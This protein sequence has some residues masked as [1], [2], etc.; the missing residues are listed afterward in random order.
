MEIRANQKITGWDIES[1]CFRK[2][3]VGRPIDMPWDKGQTFYWSYV[4][5]TVRFDKLTKCRIVSIQV[6][7]STGDVKVIWLDK[8]ITFEVRVKKTAV[9]KGKLDMS[10]LKD[11]SVR[12]TEEVISFFEK[13]GTGKAEENRVYTLKELR[14]AL[15]EP[16]SINQ[17]IAHGTPMPEFIPPGHDAVRIVAAVNAINAG[18]PKRNLALAYK[19]RDG[20]ASADLKQLDY[21]ENDGIDDTI[22]LRIHTARAEGATRPTK[23]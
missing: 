3:G 14:S 10:R 17:G 20:V 23:P 9:A 21:H 5:D 8:P 19:C 2:I 15:G 12:T 16:E 13:D 6:P 22:K 7:L 4:W 1:E 18:Y 11:A